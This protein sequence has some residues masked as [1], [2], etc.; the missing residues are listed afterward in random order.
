MSPSKGWLALAVPVL[1]LLGVATLVAQ[2]AEDDVATPGVQARRAAQLAALT[3]PGRAA[4]AQRMVAWDRLPPL[5]RAQQRGQYADWRALDQAT[6]ARL[7]AA[8][9]TLAT[10]PPSQQQAMLA[11]FNQLDTAQQAGW[12][13]GP[14]VG[15]DYA[16][17]HPL[18]AF[19]PEAEREPM[20]KVLQQMT[21]PQR[22]DLAV[23]TQRTPPQQR[24]ALR[25]ALIATTAQSRGQW[26]QEHLR[27]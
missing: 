20:R 7:Q 22:A 24:D 21:A 27:R 11:R 10:L 2:P 8:A 16:R 17:L 12:R 4:F 5:Q 3:E 13:M 15:A 18:L 19:M 9:A 14:D 25:Q 26:L 23:L 6:R 1:L